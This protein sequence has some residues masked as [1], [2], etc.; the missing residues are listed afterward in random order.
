MSTK[1]FVALALGCVTLVCPAYLAAQ[2][3]QDSV[4]DAA[5]KARAERKNV[6]PAKI[7]LDNDNLDTLKGVVNVVGQSSAPAGD[8]NKKADDKTP[9]TGSKG[10]AKDEAYWRQ[11]FAAANKKLADDSHELDV[12]QR[13]RNLKQQQYY[14]DPMAALKQDYSRQDL[15]DAKAKIDELTAKVEQDKADISNL[16]DELRQAGGDPG[17][18]TPPSQSSQPAATSETSPPAP[19]P[20]PAPPVPAPAPAP[21]A[22]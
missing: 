5:R 19:Q 8:E 2:Q 21:A 18:A 22:Q 17:W 15:N 16:E 7:V 4:A 12:T 13:E 3:D 6:P 14:T 9:Q 20:Q 10:P 11:K 1:S